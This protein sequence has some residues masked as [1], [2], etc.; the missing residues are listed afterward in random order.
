[1]VIKT[2]ARGLV[3]SGMTFG[4]RHLQ[5]SSVIVE[6]KDT[7]VTIAV[8]ESLNPGF[9]LLLHGSWSGMYGTSL[10]QSEVDVG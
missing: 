3:I 8:T 7:A 2:S 6:V 10:R 5:S 4:G 1:M 9:P